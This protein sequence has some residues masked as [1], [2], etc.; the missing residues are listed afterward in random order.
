MR[1]I[2]EMGYT[3]VEDILDAMAVERLIEVTAEL[4]RSGRGGAR[5]L[6]DCAE[7]RALAASRILR[8]LVEPVLGC[9]CFAVRALYFDK[10]PESNWKVPWHQDLVIAVRERMDDAA[11][12]GA[13]SVKAGVPHVEPPVQVL[14]QM[15]AVRIHLDDCGVENGPLR[16][17]PGS[18]RLGRLTG[19]ER[20]D[21]DASCCVRR[22]GAILMRP[23]LLH[24]SSA[25]ESPGHRRVI[26]IEYAVDELPGGVQWRDRVAERDA[27]YLSPQARR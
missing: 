19:S 3:V 25:A 23:L 5:N 9:E 10:T 27:I 12:Y 22:G 18:H 4:A 21:G 8:D 15:L 17:K 20:I 7:I 2:V 13:W 16:M 1:D 14:T 11:G 24:A 26:H 6:L